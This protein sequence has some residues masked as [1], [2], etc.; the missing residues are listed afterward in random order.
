MSRLLGSARHLWRSLPKGGSLP[1]ETWLRRHDRIVLLVWLHAAGVFIY[2][3]VRG[4]APLHSL[5]ESS[6]VAVAAVLGGSRHL[7]RPVRAGAATLGLVSA[8]AILTHLSGGLIEMHFHFFV[9]VGIISLYQDWMPFLLALGFVVAHH[10]VL[11]ALDPEGVFNHPAAINHPWKWAGIHGGFILAESVVLLIAWR[12]NER[13][14]R[15]PL[16]GL[17]NRLL[18]EDRINHTLDRANERGGTLAVLFLD[19]DEFKGVNDNLGHAAGDELLVAAAERI[20]GCVRGHDTVARLGG[21]EFAILLDGGDPTS[22]AEVCERIFE[23]L[24]RP[25]VLH[26]KELVITVSIG[27]ATNADRPTTEGILRNADVAMY[28]AKG[29][30][31]ARYENFDPEMHARTISRLEMRAELKRALEHEEFV[32]HYQPIVDLETDRLVSV[33]AVIRWKHPTRGMIYP[34]E[35]ITVAEE[36]GQIVEIGAWVIDEACRQLRHW[37]SQEPGARDL[38]LNVNLSP[39]QLRDPTTA[40]RV[41][42]AIWRNGINPECLVLEITESAALADEHEEQTAER[43]NQL[44]NLGI[45]LALDDFG[46]GYSS[47]ARLGRLPVDSIKIDKS[48]VDGLLHG[49]EDSAL[50][51]AVLKLG[52]TLG[53]ETTAEGIETTGQLATLRSLGCVNGQGFYLSRPID[54]DQVP[55]LLA[56]RDSQTQGAR[57]ITIK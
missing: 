39:R 16:T 8:S 5:S 13:G 41:A 25:F 43:L 15:D 23:A 11:G 18:F 9:M 56:E 6:I 53:L 51:R 38:R 29:N 26:G 37:R 2:A 35:F 32:L 12:V 27:V 17:A 10:G 1:Q 20:G 36:T 24:R 46:T 54:A 30:G 42:A 34:L 48:F 45:K 4:N 44:K 22:A 14:F 3:L 28:R 40:D 57:L 21:D 31:R 19:L 50:A 55:A 7:A 33:E 52:G 47:L 49:P